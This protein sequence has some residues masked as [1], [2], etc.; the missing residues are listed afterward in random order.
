MHSETGSSE[1]KTHNPERKKVAHD[2]WL[3][4]NEAAFNK[5]NVQ[6][7]LPKKGSYPDIEG[8]SGISVWYF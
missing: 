8:R 7:F 3:G 2:I 5:A 6:A 1:L 4:T